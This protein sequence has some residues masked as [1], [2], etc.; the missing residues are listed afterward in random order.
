[1]GTSVSRRRKHGVDPSMNR[2]P[3]G[4]E[5]QSFGK[6]LGSTAMNNRRSPRGIFL[7]GLGLHFGAVP[8]QKITKKRR[9][10]VR[11]IL[12]SV[13]A[14]LQT[15]NLSQP[16][17]ATHHHC[18]LHLPYPMLVKNQPSLS[19]P[20]PPPLN[21]EPQPA[22]QLPSHPLNSNKRRTQTLH[23]NPHRQNQD[24]ISAPA[25]T[26]IFTS[27]IHSQSRSAPC[28]KRLQYRTA[29]L[30]ATE[31]RISVRLRSRPMSSKTSKP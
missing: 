15:N 18:P 2:G 5:D 27:L 11:L 23:N 12:G 7:L 10:N 24:P 31:P 6:W 22:T 20:H 13:T 30:S 8:A 28:P 4:E 9:N 3:H 1:M 16:T 26:Y 29:H 19:Q 25:T 21:D 17:T 14:M